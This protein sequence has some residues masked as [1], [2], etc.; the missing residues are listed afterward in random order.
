LEHFLAPLTAEAAEL[1]GILRRWVIPSLFDV[2]EDLV[3]KVIWVE[4]SLMRRDNRR[5][6]LRE[7]DVIAGGQ[8]HLAHDSRV[9]DAGPAFVHDLGLHLRN[10]ILHFLVE[11]RHDIPLPILKYIGILHNKEDEIL[12][13]Q[14]LISFASVFLG[15]LAGR[16]D[17]SKLVLRE[18]V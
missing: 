11:H 13:G 5:V 12:L 8:I 16:F 10:E 15:G 17:K 18:E 2:L 4:L 7:L 9:P 6:E 3:T 14:L 1:L